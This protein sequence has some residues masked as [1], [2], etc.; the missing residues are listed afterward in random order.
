MINK[1]DEVIEF[2]AKELGI[3]KMKLK[4]E[5]RMFHDLGVDGDDAGEFIVAFSKRFDVDISDFIF[6]D[7]FGN[8]GC[9]PFALFISLFNSKKL[10]PL[11]VAMLIEA[12]ENKCWKEY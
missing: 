3:S 6:N 9:N 5:S 11:T 7:Y 1:Q 4:M 12:A 8:E 10:K 2:I